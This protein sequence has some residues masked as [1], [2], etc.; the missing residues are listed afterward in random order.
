ME[1][2]LQVEGFTY[3]IVLSEKVCSWS[4]NNDY[5]TDIMGIKY[6]FEWAL[7]K[8]IVVKM[9]LIHMAFIKNLWAVRSSQLYRII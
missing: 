4:G 2:V 9:E 5:L 3:L 6:G 1:A 7:W 8:L